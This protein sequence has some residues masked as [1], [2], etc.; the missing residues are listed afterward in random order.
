MGPVWTDLECH[1]LIS[2]RSLSF[3]DPWM[4]LG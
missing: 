3:S 4:G 2:I 1:S